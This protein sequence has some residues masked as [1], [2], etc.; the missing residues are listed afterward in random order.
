[1]AL[2]ARSFLFVGL[3]LLGTAGLAFV[4]YRFL[5]PDPGGGPSEDPPILFTD[6]TASA[7]ITFRHVNGATGK[8][9]LPETMGAGVA[10]VDF[11]RDGRP[12]LFFVNGRQ[13][14]GSPDSSGGRAVQSLYRN[15][16][17]GTFEDVTAA[18]GLAVELYGMGVAV[19]DYDNDGWPDLFVT[20]VGGN[21]LFR[22]IGG[23][24]FEDVTDAAGLGGQVSLPATGF[25]NHPAPIPFPASA[26]FLDYDGDGRLDLFVCNYLTWSPALDLGVKA[27]LP[28]GMRAYVPPQQFSGAHCELYRNVGGKRFEDVSASAGARITEP[29][30]PDRRPWPVG[31]SLGVVVCDPDRDGWPDLIVANDTVRNFFFHNVPAPGGGRRFEEEGLFAGLA[32]ADIRP[33]GGMGVDAGEL[34]PDTFAVVVANFTNE[35]N[36]L[37]RRV[38]TNPVRFVDVATETGLAGASRS[39]MK[40]GALFCDFDRDGR[41]D[42]FT[43]NGHLEPD[44]ATAQPGQ[45]YA[46]LPQ[47]FWN[48]GDGKHLF[49][50]VP[51]NASQFPP[52]VGRGCA[53]LDYDGDGAPDLVVTENNGSARLFRNVTP[54]RAGWVRLHLT[55]SGPT[56]R[57]A[58]GAEVTV[59]TGG[60]ARRWYVSP[61]H[62]YLSQSELS[63]TFGL[64]GAEIDRVTVRWPCGGKTQEWKGLRAGG[65]YDLIEG[66]AEP[67]HAPK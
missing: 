36:S 28:G 25:F 49:D 7:G 66:V 67:T 24:R 60:V 16:G 3:V 6:V 8:K 43:C 57:D 44:I 17:D 10:V 63:A 12:D 56:N 40:F 32:N 1:M 11:D 52:I 46:Q 42:L 14:P 2:P 26:T 5:S 31:K 37:F 38:S 33:R 45:I 62:G 27:I 61:T 50:P 59:E 41:P 18:V 35:P 30:G 47:L 48:T 55:G 4:A 13:W 65:T 58:I 20:A 51:G 29:G 34:T 21:R 19:G 53:Y 22:N 9:L 39:P 23:K 15:R 64:A 54:A